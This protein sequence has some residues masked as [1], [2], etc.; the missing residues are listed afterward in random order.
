MVSRKFIIEVKLSTKPAWQIAY[1][2]DLHPNVLS[3]IMSGAVRTKPGDPRVVR[4]G[5]ILGLS[6]EDCFDTSSEHDDS[7]QG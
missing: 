6:E 2:A 7:M 1:A 3:K 4:V 5:K